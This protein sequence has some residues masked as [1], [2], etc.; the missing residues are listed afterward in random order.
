MKKLQLEQVLASKKQV[1]VRSK[2]DNIRIARTRRS[3]GYHW[4][5][6]LVKRF[7]AL[8]GWK[9]FRLGSPSVGLPDILAVSTKSGTIFT[10]E[11]KSGTTN[12]LVVPFDQILRCL[13]WTDT[14][15]LYDTRKVVF[16][17]KFL[18]KKR[19]GLSLYEKRELR[20]YYKVWDKENMISDIACNYDGS[21][22][23]IIE[24]KRQK[25]T[26]D[27]YQMPFV[28]RNAKIFTQNTSAD[29]FE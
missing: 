1:K 26:L 11:A 14:F 16:A 28:S 9:A 7:N 6:T 22:Y 29:N 27:D 13:K 10:I 19:I 2:K 8:E 15:E 17:F 20:E 12:S 23:S 4:E 21:T 25:L 5:D 24:G 18:S 3:R